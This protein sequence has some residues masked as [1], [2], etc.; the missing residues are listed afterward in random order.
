MPAANSCASRPSSAA[1]TA[2]GRMGDAGGDGMPAAATAFMRAPST[3]PPARPAVQEPTGA[4]RSLMPARC[5][6]IRRDGAAWLAFQVASAGIRLPPAAGRGT[7]C[8]D[9]CAKDCVSLSC[10][11]RPRARGDAISG[12]GPA[13]ILLLACC[14]QEARRQRRFAQR[15]AWLPVRCQP[16]VVRRR[17]RRRAEQGRYGIIG[18][19]AALNVASS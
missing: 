12:E 14:V 1:A 6:F 15:D 5:L 2:G 18:P 13:N 7:A 17:D 19:R 3:A 4:W 16:L 9:R 11:A 10:A 8:A